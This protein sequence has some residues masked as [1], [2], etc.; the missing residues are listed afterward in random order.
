MKKIF[1]YPLLIT[2]T[3]IIEIPKSFQVT[4]IAEQKSVFGDGLMLWALV[5]PEED[6]V[7]LQIKIH[8]TGHDI[9][10]DKFSFISSVIM[11]NGLV[12]HIFIES[13]KN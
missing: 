5:N 9:D 12:W 10:T 13:F 6:K 1:K 4:L 7:K 2:G 3:Q 11:A 8:G